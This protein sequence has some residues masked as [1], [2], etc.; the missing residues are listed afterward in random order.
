MP[1]EAKIGAT[2]TPSLERMIKPAMK[3]ITTLPTLCRICESVV[4]RWLMRK[5]A[6]G[7]MLALMT[8]KMLSI[9]VV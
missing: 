7:L 5:A 3:R 8:L 6:S 1:A 2:F 9:A 4:A